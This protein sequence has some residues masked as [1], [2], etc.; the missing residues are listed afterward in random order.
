MSFLCRTLPLTA[1][2]MIAAAS[3]T[4][5]ADHLD[6]SIASA[7]LQSDIADV[8]LFRSPV[9]PNNVVLVATHQSI[10]DFAGG[11]TGG[12]MFTDQGTYAFLIDTGG[13]AREEITLSTK[14][15]ENGRKFTM[16][17]FTFGSISGTVTPVGTAQPL[18]AEKNGVKI[19]AGPRDDPFFFDLIGFREFIAAVNAPP[20]YAPAL[21]L[22]S[23]A[24]GVP[25]NFF[26]GNV[27]AIV[28]ELPIAF[29]TNNSNPNAGII[30]VSAKAFRN[31]L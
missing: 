7:N 8:Y 1:A 4:F 26:S 19:F 22:R 24:G 27:A 2:L 6:S 28:V 23:A 13:D 31:Q 18:I 9:N 11:N 12:A 5:A 14:F 16:S 25:V 15:T 21:G 3:P 29:L 30:K 17:G 20:V 10:F